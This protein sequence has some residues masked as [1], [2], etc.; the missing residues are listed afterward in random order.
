TGRFPPHPL[1]SQ[2]DRRPKPARLKPGT[3]P[4]AGNRSPRRR[5]ATDFSCRYPSTP[6]TGYSPSPAPISAT[7][8][9]LRGS[10]PDPSGPASFDENL[11]IVRR[12]FVLAVLRPYMR[13]GPPD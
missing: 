11:T 4:A 2:P 3:A 6:C 10:G 8:L 7:G 1:G 12:G 5:L 9:L 13:S